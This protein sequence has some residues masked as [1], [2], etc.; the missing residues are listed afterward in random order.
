MARLS[1]QTYFNGRYVVGCRSNALLFCQQISPIAGCRIR[2]LKLNRS[3]VGFN[4]PE[5]NYFIAGVAA[6]S[7]HNYYVI[8]HWWLDAVS[9]HFML[10]GQWLASAVFGCL[11]TTFILLGQWLA[12][13]VVGCS[14]NRGQRVFNSSVVG[15]SEISLYLAAIYIIYLFVYLQ[16]LLPQR[17]SLSLSHILFS[18]LSTLFINL[19]FSVYLICLLICI[20]LYLP[21]QLPACLQ[22]I[23]GYIYVRATTLNVHSYWSRLHHQY[24]HQSP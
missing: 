22:F 3:Q 12:A 18:S 19:F 23:K 13:V 24:Q 15:L 7:T 20:I 21:T 5:V 17:L 2:V 11:I 14:I 9:T 6:L 1:C 10:A 16:L 8:R 4:R